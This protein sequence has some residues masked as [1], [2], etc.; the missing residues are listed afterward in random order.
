MSLHDRFVKIPNEKTGKSNWWTVCPEASGKKSSRRPR[1][2]S[3]DTPNQGTVKPK[4][5]KKKVKKSVQKSLS[6][7]TSATNPHG[8]PCA[9]PTTQ[10]VHQWSPMTSPAPGTPIDYGLASSPILSTRNRRLPNSSPLLSPVQVEGKPNLPYRNFNGSNNSLNETDQR[11]E[12][13]S[14]Q[15]ST[16]SLYDSYPPNAFNSNN[17]HDQYG[18]SS[19]LSS[20]NSPLARLSMNGQIFSFPNPNVSMGSGCTSPVPPAPQVSSG[21]QSD[22]EL[23]SP[24]AIPSPPPYEE[25]VLQMQGST[26]STPQLLHKHPL[27]LQHSFPQHPQH[28]LHISHAREYKRPR[29]TSMP[30]AIGAHERFPSDLDMNLFQNAIAFNIDV[31]KVLKTEVE[32]GG[33]NLD[34]NMDVSGNSPL[35]G[36]NGASSCD[37]D[38]FVDQKPH[39]LSMG[40]I[41][42]TNVHGSH[43]L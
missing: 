18:S 13:Y 6:V 43:V 34:F 24:T 5:E 19:S 7:D 31:S 36:E 9:S 16:D 1:S 14:T 20:L 26:S 30:I 2:S 4:K 25:A 35:N 42:P 39:I 37:D 12:A 38:A 10:H 3:I 29:S 32:L 15:A 17:I 21:I 41:P 33:G 8:S 11:D 27:T 40:G 28:P 22:I 23:S